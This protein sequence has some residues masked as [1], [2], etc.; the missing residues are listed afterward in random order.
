VTAPP[1]PPIPARHRLAAAIVEALH[2]PRARQIL[3]DLARDD[4]AVR[5]WLGP[6][7]DPRGAVQAR[8]RR[9]SATVATAVLGLGPATLAA[10]L[11][12]AALLFDAGLFFETHEVLE[13]HW[14]QAS[15]SEREALQGLIQIA[16]GYQH[17]V[18]G[19]A[20]GARSLLA[21]GVARV[22]G[23]RLRGMGL[24]SF[25]AAVARTIGPEGEEGGSPAAPPFPR[26]LARGPGRPPPS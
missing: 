15:L 11:D 10:A 4:T 24:D 13:P 1:L 26:P 18:N 16:V 8:A 14:R 19:N 7:A 20:R 6:D 5:D 25:A 2:D 21:D 12:D 23:R 9:A 17:R 22:R 3:A